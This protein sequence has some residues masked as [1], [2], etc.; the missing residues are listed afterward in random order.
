MIYSWP[1]QSICYT[2]ERIDREGHGEDVDSG[3]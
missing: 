1:R 3:G 2:V